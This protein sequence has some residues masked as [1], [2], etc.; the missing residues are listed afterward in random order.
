MH[1][2]KQRLI[3]YGSI[4]LLLLLF[5]GGFIAY[6]YII[7]NPNIPLLL[8]EEGADWIRY[9]Q[10]VELVSPPSRQITFFSKVFK[11]QNVSNKVIL[12]IRAM[13]SVTVWLDN[14]MIFQS[15]SV[16]QNWKQIINIDITEV[17]KPG[18]HRLDIGVENRNGHP[19]LL[20]YSKTLHLVTNEDWLATNDLKKWSS[21]LSTNTLQYPIDLN[22]PQIISY[23]FQRTD[24]ALLSHLP[25]YLS[26]FISIF[27]LTLLSSLKRNFNWLNFNGIVKANH[28]H[29]FVLC[30]WIVMAINNMIKLPLYVGMDYP[31]QLKYIK[32]I[33]DNGSIPLA[34]EGW[35]MF[36][37]PLYY[38]L[39]ALLYKTLIFFLSIDYVGILLRIIPLTCGALQIEMCWQA[40]KYA[41]PDRDDLKTLGIL[42]GGLLPMNIYISQVIGNEPLVGC[43][44]SITVIIIIRYLKVFPRYLNQS[45]GIIGL[46]LGLAMLTKLTVF[47][48]IPPVLLAV[49]FI[50]IEERKYQKK[51]Y[52]FALKNISIILGFAFI[53]SGWYFIRNWINF[54]TFIINKSSNYEW[55]QEPGYR[56]IE[57]FCNFG[58]S[59]FYPIYS[60]VIGIWD[61][62][63]STFWMDGNLSGIG[64]Y[65]LR[66]PWNY[67][68]LLSSAWFSIL[69]SFAIVLGL[70]VSFKNPLDKDRRIMFF[71]AL[72][73]LVY[74]AS[75]LYLFLT[76]PMYC[77]AKATYTISIMPCFVILCV[78]GFKILTQNLFLKSFCYGLVACWAVSAYCAY[79][80]I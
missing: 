48:L 49:A 5:W 15:K 21:A 10:P 9:R 44:S 34:T 57:Q 54:D 35:Q 79:F 26:I 31:E 2:L 4:F 43:L 6:Q 78:T 55:W 58:K 59:L 62:L 68:F 23:K 51:A 45:F 40:L 63:Y 73:V 20:A 41:F 17:L 13:K 1:T 47:P 36:Q 24:Y 65:Q 19:A 42:I 60:N 18:T 25:L 8:K 16:V 77:I 53:V 28:V 46:I 50:S 32:Y 12:S 67:S 61:S 7:D 37:P 72:C 11:F 74:T 52:L 27:F 64:S 33:V 70:V 38:L 14:T 69:P 30:A 29:W 66:P 3:I 39:S 80:I 75:I 56:T 22:D 76:I 71:S